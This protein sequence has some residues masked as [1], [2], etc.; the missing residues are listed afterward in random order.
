MLALSGTSAERCSPPWPPTRQTLTDPPFRQ[1]GLASL[2][3][4]ATGDLAVQEDTKVYLV[5]ACRCAPR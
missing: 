4:C 1:M 5:Q 3:E 2:V